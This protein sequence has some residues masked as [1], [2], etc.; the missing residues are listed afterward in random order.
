MGINDYTINRKTTFPSGII[1]NICKGDITTIKCDAVVNAANEHLFHGGGVAAAI[2]KQGG[3]IIQQESHDWVE[4][5][6]PISH[7][8][9]AFTTGGDLP[10]KYVI[11]ALGPRWGEGDEDI[12]LATAIRAS[13]QLANKFSVQTICFPAI[14]TGIFGFPT[15]RA[16][17]IL[18]KTISTFCLKDTKTS[19][20]NITLVL[21]D[22]ITMELFIK[23][24][25]N[26]HNLGKPL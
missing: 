14:S 18:L 9:P 5:N 2:V 16:A 11:H 23:C 15:D 12:K 20:K 7:E 1:L 22:A 4:A 8:S 19:L 26:N 24:F 10:C 17:N 13:L 6:G 25:D 21:F 3:Q